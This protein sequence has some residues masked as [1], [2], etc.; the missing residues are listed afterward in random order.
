MR[1]DVRTS[2]PRVRTR[3]EAVAL[4]TMSPKLREHYRSFDNSVIKSH[5]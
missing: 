5:P 3:G 4:S 1:F 2:R